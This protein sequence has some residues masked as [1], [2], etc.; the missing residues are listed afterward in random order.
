MNFKAHI[1]CCTNERPAG[2]E[3]G[4]C[5]EKGSLKLLSYMK[6]RLKEMGISDMRVNSSGCLDMCEQGPALV[7]YPEGVWYHYESQQDVDD[8]IDQ[9]LLKGIRVERL[10]MADKK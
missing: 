8:I 9:H 2:S 1:F 10:L 3:R 7:I 6:G 4:C 5:K